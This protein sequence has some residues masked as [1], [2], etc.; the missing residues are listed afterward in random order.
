[1]TA[2]ACTHE[3]FV[4]KGIISE[5]RQICEKILCQ[6]ENLKY[7]DDA[8]FAIRLAME[9]SIINAVKHGNKR[10]PDKNVIIEYGLSAERLDLWVTDEG[11]GFDSDHLADPR[12]EENIYKTNGRGVLLI[13]AYMDVVEYN[14]SGN[15]VHM[16]K[17]NRK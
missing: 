17:Y 4:S 9:E 12:R 2:K 11:Q 3:K 16:T 1:M 15:S 6:A 8:L 7:S 13:R 10:N 14:E 5:L